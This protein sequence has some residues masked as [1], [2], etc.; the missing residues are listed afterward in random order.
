LTSLALAVAVAVAVAAV[1]VAVILR[2]TTL[3]MGWMINLTQRQLVL[4]PLRQRVKCHGL[5]WG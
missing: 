2:G 1:A 5:V 3:M 4:T